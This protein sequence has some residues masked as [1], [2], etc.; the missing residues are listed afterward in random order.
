MDHHK[1]HLPLGLAIGSALTAACA[2]KP[3]P[4]ASG[5]PIELARY[6]ADM[7]EYHTSSG[8][9]A[10]GRAPL[11]EPTY[12][13]VHGSVDDLETPAGKLHRELQA[14]LTT[15]DS[16]AVPSSIFQG[17]CPDSAN[18]AQGFA[19]GQPAASVRIDTLAIAAASVVDYIPVGNKLCKGPQR[20]SYDEWVILVEGTRKDV[21]L[22]LN[23]SLSPC[24]K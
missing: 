5:T 2:I 19:L 16:V 4:P 7:G 10:R 18:V 21:P 3:E 14:R 22:H 9:T 20:S 1:S 24:Y 11:R 12:L 17:N 23:P 13:P 15:Y 6:E 8:H